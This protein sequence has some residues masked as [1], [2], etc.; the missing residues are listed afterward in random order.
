[1]SI[2]SS[3]DYGLYNKYS[4]ATNG[5]YDYCT[6]TLECDSGYLWNEVACQCFADPT[7]CSSGVNC[8]DQNMV[9]NPSDACSCLDA[10]AVMDMYIFPSWALDYIVTESYYN[11]TYGSAETGDYTSTCPI[12]ENA[13]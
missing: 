11:M 10:F 3:I 2:Q 4:M 12:E 1:M 13:R 6:E 9:S 8:L 5:Y 7:T